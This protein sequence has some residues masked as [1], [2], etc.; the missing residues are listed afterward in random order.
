M[1]LS[2]C[3]IFLP[4]W[5]LDCWDSARSSVSAMGSMLGK[6]GRLG[7]V[8]RTPGRLFGVAQELCKL[9]A[10]GGGRLGMAAPAVGAPLEF[11]YCAPGLSV[12][13]TD[14]FFAHTQA[15]QLS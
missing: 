7:R 6:T 13:I 9:A 4:N 1:P 12:I 11:L 8:S 10:Q 5:K 2:L 3:Y 15:L 14:P